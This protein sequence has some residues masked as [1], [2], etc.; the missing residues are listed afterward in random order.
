MSREALAQLLAT[1]RMRV[2][3][4][5][6]GTTPLRLEDLRAWAAALRT[7]PAKLLGVRPQVAD[8]LLEV[9]D[10]LR[11]NGARTGVSGAPKAS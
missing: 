4:V 7:T 9:V 10:Q 11:A 5:E 6:N 3:R 8:R 1:K 2:W